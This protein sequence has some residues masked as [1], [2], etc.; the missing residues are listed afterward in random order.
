MKD[1]YKISEISKLYDIG[2]DSLRY[3]ERLGILKPRRDLNG[4]RL[5]GLKDMYKLNNIRDLR[6]LGFSMKQIKEYLDE[7]SIDK[8]LELLHQEQE[9]LHTQIRQLQLQ[10]TIIKERIT[11]MNSSRTI[12]TGEFQVLARPDRLCVQL[13]QHITRDEEMDIIIKRLHQKHEDKIRD[14]GNQ[15]IG[16]FL[17]MEDVA[18]GRTNSYNSVFFI[19]EQ[20]TADYDFVLPG[21]SYLSCYYRGGYEQNARRVKEVM[22]YAQANG[23]QLRGEPFEMYQTDNR[24]TIQEEEFLTE[25]Q[26]QVAR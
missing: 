21:G 22:A 18:E 15:V 4:Y 1:Y 9:W 12:K 17:S 19:L 7:Q 2:V 5:Y 13:N 6:R 20:A 11:L 23:L 25:I 3:Y 8:T 26:V 14:F 10:E 24:Y 16:A